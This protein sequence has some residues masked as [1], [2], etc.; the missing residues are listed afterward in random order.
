VAGGAEVWA[1]GGTDD[2]A[3]EAGAGI[4]TGAAAGGSAEGTG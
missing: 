3:P 2:G 4:P 1:G